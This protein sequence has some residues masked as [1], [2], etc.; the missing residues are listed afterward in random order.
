MVLGLRVLEFG[1]F[2]AKP[3]RLDSHRPDGLDSSSGRGDDFW[4]FGLLV[5]KV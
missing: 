5:F 4:G 2:F 1:V 3:L